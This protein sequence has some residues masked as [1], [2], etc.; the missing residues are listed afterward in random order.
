[1]KA[2]HFLLGALVLSACTQTPTAAVTH[3]PERGPRL[4][5]TT[6]TPC[7]KGGMTMGGGQFA[8]CP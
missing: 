7:E 3:S 8:P 2:R 4:D 1:M 5:G 6:T